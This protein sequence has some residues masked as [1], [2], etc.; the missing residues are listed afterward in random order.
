MNLPLCAQRLASRW[1]APTDMRPQV[2]LTHPETDLDLFFDDGALV[3]LQ[4]IC[5]VIYNPLGRPPSDD[6]MLQLAPDC[7]VIISEW[8]TGAGQVLFEDNKFLKAFVRSGVETLNV[9]RE[10]A[11][12]C[13]VLVVVTPAQFSHSVAE[14]TV[15]VVLALS[16]NFLNLHKQTIAGNMDH[17]FCYG[18]SKSVYSPEYPG[19]E[20][21]GE[22]MGLVGLGAIGSEVARLANAFG[23]EVVAFDPHAI[24]FPK[25]VQPV[26]FD[27]LLKTS[28]FVSL[29]AALNDETRHMFRAPEFDR[30]RADA[31]LINTARGALVH[32]SALSTALHNRSIA[33]AA[34]DAFEDEPDFS[35]SPL[36]SCPN[37]LLTPHV[38]GMTRS[39]IRRQA[40][41]C[42]DLV[43]DVLA[44]RIPQSVINPEVKSNPRLRI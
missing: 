33:G 8:L 37:V 16:R 34:I 39:T 26:D 32:D 38:A 12:R 21:R 42:V 24:E 36:L 5:D 15:G 13:G 28:R 4:E 11:T 22:R 18:V 2:F 17:A 9:D 19:F 29:H 7:D 43:R 10:A 35:N 3:R 6:E 30:M 25:Y 41:L 27:I 1:M 23:M 40:N 20:I 31:F 44:G 14:F